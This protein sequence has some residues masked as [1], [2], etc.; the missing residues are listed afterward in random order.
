MLRI[1]SGKHR[2]RILNVTQSNDV[3][4]TTTMAREAIF[5]LLTHNKHTQNEDGE[6]ILV[7]A[8]VLDL[9]AGSGALGIEA[10]SRGASHATFIDINQKHLDVV[11]GNIHTIGEEAHTTLLRADSSN[12]PRAL[13][14]CNLVFLDPPYGKKLITPTLQSLKRG[15]WLEPLA[16]LVIERPKEESLVLPEGFTLLDERRYSRSLIAIVR[17]EG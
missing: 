6:S 17:W 8:R 7:G 11:R 3:R 10:L 9:F 12:P 5:N 13:Y 15:G 16:L 4:P 2:H 14:P 1:I